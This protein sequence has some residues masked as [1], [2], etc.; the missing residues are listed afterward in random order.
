MSLFDKKPHKNSSITKKI[1]KFTATFE[2]NLCVL[3]D[4]T[5]GE[6]ALGM[7][8]SDVFLKGVGGSIPHPNAIVDEPQRP[9]RNQRPG[10]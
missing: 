4:P 9:F 2:P 8:S 5:R 3:S 1:N 10:P 7:G 6:F